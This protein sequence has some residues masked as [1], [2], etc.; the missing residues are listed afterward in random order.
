MAIVSTLM[1]SFTALTAVSTLMKSPAPAG[2]QGGA[3]GN[4]DGDGG[5][6][7]GDADDERQ[8]TTGPS[9]MTRLQ[10]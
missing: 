9:I 2:S 6:G 3:A 5:G 10:P 1:K 8:R 7:D 4:D